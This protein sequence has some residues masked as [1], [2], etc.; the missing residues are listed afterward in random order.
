METSRSRLALQ[1]TSRPSGPACSFT[2]NSS[3]QMGNQDKV[4]FK[5][6]TESAARFAWT[7]SDLLQNNSATKDGEEEEGWQPRRRGLSLITNLHP[8]LR[9]K[10]TVSDAG[11][12]TSEL[13]LNDEWMLKFI[14]E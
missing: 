2:L 14:T 3:T 8:Q 6:H 7:D 9:V 12:K 10:Q 5:K 11:K 1:L 4:Q 13:N